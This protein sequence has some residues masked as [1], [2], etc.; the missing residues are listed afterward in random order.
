MATYKAEFLSHYYQRHRRP[1]SA[2]LFGRIH[3]AATLA[4]FAPRL[5]NR[6][7]RLP[8]SKRVLSSLFGIHPDRTLPAFAA[9]SFRAWFRQRGSRRKTR[10]QRGPV[11][12]HRLRTSSNLKS[13][14]PR[15]KSWSAPVSRL[16]FRPVDLCCG[17]PLF[18][19]G[20]LDTAKR[21]LAR[22]IATLSPMCDAGKTI[23]GLEPSCLLTF[24]DELPHLFPRDPRA[25]TLAKSSLM[26]DEFLAREAPDF[27]LPIVRGGALLHGH[28]HQKAIAGLDSE[29]AILQTDFRT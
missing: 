28:C 24:R 16:R 7:A 19:Q 13:R 15:W 14:A 12:G 11:P 20:M 4:Q 27:P 3:Q 9:Q 5:A 26:L 2:H 21:W 17:R 23:V 29:V 25:A 22:V 18:D 6:M 1:L 10:A 8:L